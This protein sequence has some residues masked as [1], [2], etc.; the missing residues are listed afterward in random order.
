ML[1]GL[2]LVPGREETFNV[3]LK[4]N[5]FCLFYLSTIIVLIVASFS[6]EGFMFSYYM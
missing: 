6:L 3:V 2:R 5:E 4:W 1:K